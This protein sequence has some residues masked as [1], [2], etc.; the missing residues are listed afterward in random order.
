MKN[1]FSDCQ[2]CFEST[3]DK[4]L[5]CCDSVSC[6]QCVE[7]YIKTEMSSQC[8]NRME[9]THH[10]KISKSFPK[11][12]K[13]L[14]NNNSMNEQKVIRI[15]YHKFS[16][17]NKI[18]CDINRFLG[19]DS[20]LEKIRE[21]LDRLRT[22]HEEICPSQTLSLLTKMK[23]YIEL[24]NI[25]I[26]KDEKKN[27]EDIKF[28]ESFDKLY[29]EQKRF[30]RRA[31]RKGSGKNLF[32]FM[33]FDNEIKQKIVNLKGELEIFCRKI[34]SIVR[35]SSF[36]FPHFIIDLLKEEFPSKRFFR[37]SNHT[38]DFIMWKIREYYENEWHDPQVHLRNFP[39]QEN[40]LLY[41]C[42]RDGCDQII[43]TSKEEKTYSCE[44]CNL[45]VDE[46]SLV[47]FVKCPCC[48]MG[49]SK[50]DGCNQ[51]FCTNCKYKFDYVTKKSL[52][53]DPYFHNIHENKDLSL[54]ES[55]VMYRGDIELDKEN[56]DINELNVL[57]TCAENLRSQEG[58]SDLIANINRAS[59]EYTDMINESFT[60][61]VDINRQE[62]IS[63]SY[64][65][66]YEL[67]SLVSDILTVSNMKGVEIEN[68]IRER[69]I[70]TYI[71]KAKSQIMLYVYHII[72]RFII[73]N[74]LD[75]SGEISNL[76]VYEMKKQ[77][78]PVISE[79]IEKYEDQ[80][81]IEFFET[82]DRDN[83]SRYVNDMSLF[84]RM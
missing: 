59:Y 74:I 2:I 23:S 45:D 5:T 12:R 7:N 38:Y 82:E 63:L 60:T 73:Q 75:N 35:D 62:E 37:S 51:M 72:F 56:F 52:M 14:Q 10:I 65:D 32:P 57:F 30:L 69:G 19:E 11:L 66:F 28:Y 26:E 53:N 27:L 47:P 18:F 61:G 25:K 8:F 43:E 46:N 15:L 84:D 4:V 67:Q 33:A 24:I 79:V 70:Q 77:I 64:V 13:S 22:I 44:K 34:F 40:K 55:V 36:I 41:F 3:S 6:Q 9:E 29:I 42:P 21:V 76:N 71:C 58:P 54:N 1:K 81:S 31:S 16:E 78:I 50:I 68:F 49:I 48:S 20:F 39:E 83:V 80:F 17:I